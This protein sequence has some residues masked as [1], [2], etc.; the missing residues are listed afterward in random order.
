VL[1]VGY[2]KHTNV[3]IVLSNSS[4][5]NVMESQSVS[6]YHVHLEF[7]TEKKGNETIVFLLCVL[8]VAFG[9]FCLS[10]E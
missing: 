5:G 3:G 9:K 6:G 8:V 1:S 10:L 2:S 4:N 7:R